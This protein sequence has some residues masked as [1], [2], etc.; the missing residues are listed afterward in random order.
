[1]RVTLALIIIN[2]MVFAA[3]IIYG[4]AFIQAFSLTPVIALSGA[5]WQFLTYMFLHADP[6]HIFFN[7]F[8]LFM[9]GVVMERALGWKKYIFLYILSGVGSAAFYI[10]L[11]L[12]FLP[13]EMTVLML[14]ASGAVYGILAAFGFMFP[15]EVIYIYFIP[16][17]AMSAVFIFAGIELVAGITGVMPGIA[18]FGHLGGIITSALVMLVWKYTSKPRNEKELRQYQFYWE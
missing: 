17:P 15:K 14:G 1:M 4:D 11:T 2:V 16:L 10:F 9:F 13:G 8:A 7:M 12:T 18:N 6:L 3:E 5:W